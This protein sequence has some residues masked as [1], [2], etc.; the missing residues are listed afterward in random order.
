MKDG[1]GKFTWTDGSFYEGEFKNG[2]MEGS[3]VKTDPNG[4]RFQGNFH[5]NM[6]FG[7]GI[8]TSRFGEYKGEF[9]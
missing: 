7:F 1:F 3:G 2:L 4:N 5:R 8:H 6:I 9:K